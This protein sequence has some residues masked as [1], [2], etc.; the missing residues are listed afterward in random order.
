MSQRCFPCVTCRTS[1]FETRL[2]IASGFHCAWS[3]QDLA[4]LRESDVLAG[5]RQSPQHPLGQPLP[6]FRAFLH[7]LRY[8][9]AELWEP[10]RAPG[11]MLLAIPVPGTGQISLKHQRTRS[12]SRAS[13]CGQHSV[14][15]GLFNVY[16]LCHCFSDRVFPFLPKKWRAML[17]L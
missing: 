16:L 11:H 1:T 8:R 10:G 2:K 6:A 12:V 7:A 13:L 5:G 17:S 9:L 4:A 3:Q 14:E 15:I